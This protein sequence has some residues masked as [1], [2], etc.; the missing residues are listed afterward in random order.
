MAGHHA[1]QLHLSR[2]AAYPIGARDRNITSASA[3]VLLLL[4]L[5]LVHAL[6]LNVA[7]FDAA[8]M[9]FKELVFFSLS[10]I[11]TQHSATI[12]RTEKAM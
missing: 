6:V 2:T 8:M 9:L 11:M 7:G 3:L 4:L 12:A 5:L 10:L 1:A